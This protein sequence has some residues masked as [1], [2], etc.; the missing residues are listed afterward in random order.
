MEAVQQ[1]EESV[2]PNMPIG[3][4]NY[5][6]TEQALGAQQQAAPPEELSSPGQP[7]DEQPAMDY[8]LPPSRQP[9]SLSG[10]EATKGNSS[11]HYSIVKPRPTQQN[12]AQQAPELQGRRVGS[13]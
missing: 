4:S 6:L 9:T 11:S 5:T 2:P 12:M 10:A 1:A 3:L 7:Q 13:N 8:D